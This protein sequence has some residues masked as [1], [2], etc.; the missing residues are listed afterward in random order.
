MLLINVCMY[1]WNYGEDRS[2]SFWETGVRKSTIKK[3]KKNIGKI[4]SP[5]GKFAKQ[6][7]R[8]KILFYLPIF[9][10]IILLSCGLVRPPSNPLAL[11]VTWRHERDRLYDTLVRTAVKSK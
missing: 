5:S 11:A 3:I 8:L 4:Y 9:V 1:V 2:I 10:I 6:A 7:E